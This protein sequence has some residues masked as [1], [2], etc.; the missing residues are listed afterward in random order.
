MTKDLAFFQFTDLG[1]NAVSGEGWHVDQFIV[2]KT[3]DGNDIV[4][5]SLTGFYDFGIFNE[6]RIYLGLGGDTFKGVGGQIGV[7][8]ENEINT[9]ADN[10]II[11]GVGDSAAIWLRSIPAPV[12]TSL[13]GPGGLV[14]S[15]LVE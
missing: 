8:N 12:M 6:G 4:Q 9:G 11:T 1:D 10:D 14:L 7:K 15:I 2:V 3:L 13:K 5:G